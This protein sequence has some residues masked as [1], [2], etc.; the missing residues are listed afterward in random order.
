MTKLS[1]FLRQESGA[2]AIEYCIIAG[3]IALAIVVS[4]TTIGTKVNHYFEQV[5]A[6]N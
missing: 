5:A 1:A 3:C 4:L 6:V 2:T